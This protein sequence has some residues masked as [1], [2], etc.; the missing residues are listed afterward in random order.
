MWLLVDVLKVYLYEWLNKKFYET[1]VLNNDSDSLN[2]LV[3]ERSSV[4]SKK[5]LLLLLLF[6]VYSWC[7]ILFQKQNLKN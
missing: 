6:M 5:K 3:V 4:L 2:V 7:L 1:N